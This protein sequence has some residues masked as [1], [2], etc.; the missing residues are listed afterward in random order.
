MIRRSHELP[1]GLEQFSE[2]LVRH[3][4]HADQHAR[5]SLVMR[6]EI[7]DL[8][9]GAQPKVTFGEAH[10]RDDGVRLGGRVGRNADEGLSPNGEGRRAV[11]RAFLGAV[12]CQP[13]FSHAI[14]DRL[15]LAIMAR[16]AA[17][18]R[19]WGP[20]RVM[21]AWSGRSNGESLLM[22]V[23]RRAQASYLIIAF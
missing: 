14:E 23:V 21:A 15:H 22:P 2:G 13:Q 12:E 6:L 1:G 11:R 18:A 17:P 9:L 3:P 4:L 16:S 8:R 5:I 20:G 19:W 10:S 7:V